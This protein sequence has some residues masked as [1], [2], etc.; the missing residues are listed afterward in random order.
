MAE[1]LRLVTRPAR[2]VSPT[3]RD[4]LSVLFRQRRLAMFS[5]AS[6]FL[7][8]LAYGL[9]APSYKSEMK[10]LVQRGREDPVVAPTPSQAEFV[11]EAVTEEELN[12][13][14]ELL[15]D[16]EILRTVV[17]D[18]G[19][20]LQTGFWLHPWDND[21]QRAARAVRRLQKRL[22]V[23]TLKKTNL[24]NV[25]YESADAAETSKVLRAL[26][27]AYLA[28]H[29]QV[30]R[31]LGESTFFDR[32]VAQSRRALQQ[33]EI[34]LVDFN[35]DQGVVSAASE[36]DAVL[37]NL[38]DADADA[39]Q[40]EVA[41]SATSERIRTLEARLGG[42]PERTVTVE[43]HSDNAELMGKMKSRL[44]EL[45]LSRAELVAKYKP[46]YRSVR[47]MD[48]E[49]AETKASIAREQEEPL[50]DQTTDQNANR[51]WA[52]AELL[53]EQVELNTLKAHAVAEEALRNRYQQVAS[54]LG[55]QA[56][57]QE[58]LINDLKDAEQQY[59]L[60][61][62][63]REEARIGD[64]LDQGGI[65]NATI[66]EQPTAPALPQL[67]ALGFAAVGLLAGSV[68]SLGAAFTNDRLNRPS[69]R[70]TK[71]WHI[72]ERRCWHRCRERTGK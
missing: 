2:E 41:I 14:V 45:E 47:D 5:F 40:S 39:R 32:Q 30:H 52:K 37:R 19:L 20:S 51:E 43:R 53:K 54:R 58:R 22:T 67:S 62:N 12:S 9:I 10:V 49:I 27:D 24:I 70:P 4:L 69:G 55:E 71:F 57:Q 61:V 48:Q 13:E 23:E 36:R 64:A 26:A 56:I 63:K 18:P 21:E 60:Y 35:L 33:A 29:T 66:A 44:L 46:T 34:R 65:L 31:P 7:A 28:R 68:V 38:S 17:R 42:L 50:R 8:I 3:V 6:V 15:R 25:T 1:E 11:R 72:W 16:D 59:L